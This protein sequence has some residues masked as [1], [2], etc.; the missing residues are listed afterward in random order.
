MSLRSGRLARTRDG[1]L[2]WGGIGLMAICFAWL[3]W[4]AK[5]EGP[6]IMQV[7]GRHDPFSVVVLD[8]GHGGQDSGAMMSGLVEKDLTLDIAQRLDR[9]L[10]TQGIATVMTRVGD[11]YS[12]LAERATLT[13]RTPDCILVSIHFNEG[14]KAVSSGIE[15]YYA[16]HQITSDEPIVSWLPFLQRTAAP[17]PNL[18][19]QAL[20]GCV[21]DALVT[22][23]QALN[24]GTK[25]EQFF[26]IAKVHHPAVLVEGGF[27]SNKDETAKLA[28]PEYRERIAAAISEGICH[29]RDALRARQ[30]TLAL[31]SLTPTE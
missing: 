23:T 11:S 12:S 19:S 20:A 22:R 5:R 6:G 1:I 7:P 2:A 29:Y 18:E 28:N 27:L 25:P 14:S 16:D 26:V 31:T 21:Q 3:Q 24:R 15:T 4:T 8:P 17:A 9:L 30:S 10:Q 13:N